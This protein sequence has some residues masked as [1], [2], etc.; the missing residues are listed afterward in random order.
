MAIY[1]L[2]AFSTRAVLELSALSVASKMFF[3]SQPTYSP[4]AVVNP[5]WVYDYLSCPTS[6]PEAFVPNVPGLKD[7]F[8]G[9]THTVHQ[10]L[11]TGEKF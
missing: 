8:L 1:S 6:S 2:E 5:N 4:K 7:D 10:F 11:G 9:L 3:L